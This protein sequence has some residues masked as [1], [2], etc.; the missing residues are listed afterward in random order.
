[1]SAFSRGCLRHQYA[2][3]SFRIN[4][5]Q[6]LRFFNTTS[7]LRASKKSRPTARAKAT[8]PL[9]PKPSVSPPTSFPSTSPSVYTPYANTLAQKSHPT[10]LYQ[11]PSHLLFIVSAYTG[12]FTCYG[13]TVFLA[14]TII[15]NPPPGLAEWIPYSYGSAAIMMSAAGTWLIFSTARCIRTITALPRKLDQ[16]P[17]MVNRNMP[18][19]SAQSKAIVPA[20]EG[21]AESEL[22]IE[23]VLRKMFPVPFFPAR[24]IYAKPGEITLSS[25]LSPP[26]TKNLSAA[27]LRQMRL[28]DQARLEEEREYERNHLMTRPFRLM[29]RGLFELFIAIRKA[30]TRDGLTKVIVKGQAYKLDVSGGWALDGGRALERLA[31][32]KPWI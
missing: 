20:V 17:R 4:T 31:K 32:I 13:L 19:A 21:G 1:M 8:S 27:E 30:W 29:S 11:A 9:P 28:E 26:P 6:P 5:I 22:Q 18:R 12:A 24:V 7:L 23:V 2:L 25:Q 3:T 16:I 14:S 15:I 10:L